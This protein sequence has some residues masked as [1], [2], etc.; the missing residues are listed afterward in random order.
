MVKEGIATLNSNCVAW[1]IHTPKM[2]MHALSSAF[3]GRYS[4]FQIKL[5]DGRTR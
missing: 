1:L 2:H 3:C 4:V 5:S